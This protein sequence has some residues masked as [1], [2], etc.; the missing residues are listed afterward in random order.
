MVS[1]DVFGTLLVRRL[2]V[3]A[4]Q[5]RWLY[6]VDEALCAVWPEGLERPTL[7]GIRKARDTA[8]QTCRARTQH[9]GGDE[10]TL[11]SDWL[12]E[13]LA[14][15]CDDHLT[16][17]DRRQLCDALQTEWQQWECWVCSAPAPM[18][19]LC[20]ALK[21][22]GVR[23]IF[24]SDMYLSVAQVYQLLDNAGYAGLFDAGYTSGAL[25]VAKHTGR[26]FAKMRRTEKIPTAAMLHIGDNR[27]PDYLAPLAQG[28]PAI[29][30]F[31]S[32]LALHEAVLDTDWQLL[33][34]DSERGGALVH[35]YATAA[36]R[37]P[38]LAEESHEAPLWRLGHDLYGPVIANVVHQLHAYVTEHGIEAVYFLAREGLLFKQA[39]DQLVQTLNLKTAPSG[40]L[41]IS[42]LTSFQATTRTI[43]L[44]EL[45]AVL[46]NNE[47]TT[48]R[49]CLSVAPLHEATLVDLAHDYGFLSPDDPV[50]PMRDPAFHRLIED[51]RVTSAL[52]EQQQASWPRLLKHLDQQAFFS[53]RRVALVDVGW[54]GQIQESLVQA[55]SAL[56]GCPEIHGF[57]LGNNSLASRRAES[58]LRYAAASFCRM[59]DYD[60][61]G[62]A[63]FECLQALE[64]PTRAP[65]GTTLGYTE[66]GSPILAGVENA[67]RVVEMADDEAIR[68]LQQGMLHYV[69]AYARCVRMLGLC[70]GQT[71][72]FAAM[73]LSRIIRFPGPAEAGLLLATRAVGN[74]GG[75]EIRT[76]G[77]V[78]TWRRPLS[79]FRT[80]RRAMWREGSLSGLALL[81][82]PAQALFVA[83][84]AFRGVY[85]NR[86]SAL[87]SRFT[88]GA[89]V[90]PSVTLR[91]EI[92][93]EGSHYPVI[94]CLAIETEAA[95]DVSLTP[96]PAVLRDH[97]VRNLMR[98]RWSLWLQAI[99]GFGLA[100]LI[101]QGRWRVRLPASRVPWRPLLITSI[102]VGATYL[103][104]LCRV[105]AWQ[106]RCLVVGRRNHQ[107]LINADAIRTA[108]LVGTLNARH[109]LR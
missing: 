40:Y 2:S 24:A 56:P 63:A 13:W 88:Q 45:H 44:R 104:H 90:R 101:T 52:N 78:E 39:Y 10:E 3:A 18:L 109:V 36:R 33:Q 57:Y 42:R 94:P 25:G 80:V 14:M 51:P 85:R 37:P 41:C 49:S 107:L 96:D 46:L 48:L 11:M 35:G 9:A 50:S 5:E 76:V 79:L 58:G 29:G 84:K 73:M 8:W 106:C 21:A 81:R 97:L 70:A 103:K 54:G 99:L 31:L 38:T 86:G 91:P 100:R 47:H 108:E 53:G 74:M 26:L 17:H 55:L 6:S 60:W 92:P 62:G 87:H 83:A 71:S 1:F 69:A 22:E 82:L 59:D 16:V 72:A 32:E 77:G 43:G 12:S 30:L 95:P 23:L 27:R 93:P 66:D 65:H 61:L 68:T 4:M 19:S 20:R 98:T 15:L 34:T 75:D 102:T 89:F 105:T 28:I 64:V 67:A 7:E